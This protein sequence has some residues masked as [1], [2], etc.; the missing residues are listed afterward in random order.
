[1]QTIWLPSLYVVEFYFRIKPHSLQVKNHNDMIF[2]TIV[3]IEHPVFII[4][5]IN[6]KKR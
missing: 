5:Q 2:L 6:I 3:K 1:M 4:V